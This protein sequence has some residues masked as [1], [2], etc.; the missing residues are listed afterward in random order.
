ML[1]FEKGSPIIWNCYSLTCHRSLNSMA[2]VS[3]AFIL[4]FLS[5]DAKQGSR[6]IRLPC[7]DGVVYDALPK[8][9]LNNSGIELEAFQMQLMGMS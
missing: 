1:S 6:M 2:I 4:W 3:I 9:P 7:F 8:E 5:L